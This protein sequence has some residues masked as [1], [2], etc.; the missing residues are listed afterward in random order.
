MAAPTPAELRQIPLFNAITDAHLAELVRAF[1]AKTLAPGTTLFRAGELADRLLVLVRGEISLREGDTE[2]FLLRPFSPVGEL[3]AVTGLERRLTAVC[4][5]EC[6]VLEMTTAALSEFCE[7]HGDVAYPVHHNLLRIVADKVRRDQRRQGEMQHNLIVTQKAMKRMRELLLESD[8]S[9]LHK[10]L[11]DELD[12]LIE[13]NKKARYVVEPSRA[14]T[15]SVR[16]DD[17]RSLAVHALSRE[18]LHVERDAAPQ[19]GASV[20]YVLTVGAAELP[21]SGTVERVEGAVSVVKL[22]LLIDDYARTLE[23]ALTRLQMLDVVL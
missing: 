22:D 4:A 18:V 19:A 15:A 7:T 8:D 14:I 12:A 10:Q 9:P 16:L 11:F 5:T 20:S 6:D 3:G 17:G 21:V 23:D 1:Q 2:R 13:Q